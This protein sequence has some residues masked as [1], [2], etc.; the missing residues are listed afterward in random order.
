MKYLHA[1]KDEEDD[2]PADL[3]R[4]PFNPSEEVQ[5]PPNFNEVFHFVLP[6]TVPGNVTVFSIA[7][8]RPRT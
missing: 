8:S 2:R 4:E 5:R 6:T 3:H 7:K 1:N